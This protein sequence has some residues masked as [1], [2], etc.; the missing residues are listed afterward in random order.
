MAPLTMEFESFDCLLQLSGARELSIE[1]AL[2][3]AR[4]SFDSSN[5]RA[6]HKFGNQ[7]LW[8]DFALALYEYIGK[9]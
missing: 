7:R 3:T 9:L 1:D 2:G 6:L 5:I 4:H 8:E